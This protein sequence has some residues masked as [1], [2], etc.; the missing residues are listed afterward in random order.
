MSTH[1]ASGDS[2]FT[3]A[4]DTEAWDDPPARSQRCLYAQYFV[5][6]LVGGA[7]SS[8]TYGLFQGYLNV[9]AHVLPTIRSLIYMPW[10]FKVL[11]G[12]VSDCFPIFNFRRKPYI[13]IGWLVCSLALLYLSAR[14]L[15]DPYWCSGDARETFRKRRVCNSSA[16]EQ[17]GKY[18]LTLMLAVA[19][20]VTA[21]VAADGLMVSIAR[22][23]DE[24]VR[25]NVQSGVYMVREVGV[26]TSTL[27]VSVAFSGRDYNGDFEWGMSFPALCLLLSLPSAGMMVATWWFMDE[28][29]FKRDPST[30][31]TYMSTCARFIQ[32]RAVLHILTFQMLSS[33]LSNLTTPSYAAVKQY[34]AHVR[35]FQ[36]NL[37]QASS[38][39]T[40]L[41]GIWLVK[42]RFLQ[43]D[44][45][46]LIL[47]S[48]AMLLVLDAPFQILTTFG[49]VRNQYFYMSEVFASEL[50]SGINFVV[51][52]LVI[53][54]MADEGNEGLVYGVFTTM[55][56]TGR[57]MG[58]AL[59]N[60]LYPRLFPNL[61]ES[62]CYIDDD[63][64]FRLQVLFSF[65]TSYAL[66]AS[67]CAF[68]CL[69]PSQKKE[70]RRR[71]AEWPSEPRNAVVASCMICLG[72]VYSVL[73]N[74]LSVTPRTMCSR[75]FGG[76]GCLEGNET[77]YDTAQQ[78]AP[79]SCFSE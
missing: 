12:F 70:A 74:S 40:F 27:F 45:R 39:C 61:D 59:A 18:A 15:P 34:W 53:V 75:W 65:L 36:A 67:S 42:T 57:P 32:S 73:I 31:R 23:E 33:M 54:E 76:S 17:G 66:Q 58:R 62:R 64:R 28:P 26:I 50:P 77:R 47:A 38:S 24:R 52:S 48:T 5:V 9:P 78:Q 43:S 8:T 25:G 68:L 79:A 71:K 37:F 72:I 4:L 7:I 21:D 11:V 22:S 51:M 3:A 30:V 60:Q 13:V 6:G 20:Y 19:G 10:S 46:L 1:V 49:V 29:R 55:W 69:L 16:S 35:S 14:T 41:L 56:N 44:W 63:P 2:P